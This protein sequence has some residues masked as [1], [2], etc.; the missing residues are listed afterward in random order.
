MPADL[1]KELLQKKMEEEKFIEQL[2]NAKNLEDYVMPVSVKAELRSYQRVGIKW[3][4]FL[5]RYQLHG[6][7]CD[8][9]GL[10]KTLQTICM[11][12][13][14]HH[15]KRKGGVEMS[16]LIVCPPTLCR[17]WQGEIVKFVGSSELRPLLYSGP[18]A[19]RAVIYK[20]FHRHNVIIS[21]YDVVRNDIEILLKTHWNYVVLD[22]GHIIK[23][24]KTKTTQA[25][26]QLRSD[27][28]LILS[29]TPIQNSV[30]E[31]WSLFDYLM[32]GFLG[33]EKQF[34]AKY[35]RP[36]V[37]SRDSKCSARDQEAGALAMEALHR[38]VLPFILRRMKEDVLKDLPPKITQD[39]Y[40][41]LS[42]IQVK[43]YEDFTRSK[44]HMFDESGASGEGAKAAAGSPQKAHVFQALQYLRKVC[45]HPK[46]VVDREHR[47]FASVQAMLRAS[48]SNMDDISHAAKLP[49]L[50]D[51]LL[52][53]GIG[54]PD[55]GNANIV[56]QHRALIFFQLKSMM[57]IVERDLLQKVMPSVSYL[58]LDGSVPVFDRQ[59]IVDRFNSD[60]SIDALLIS[61]A[62][63]ELVD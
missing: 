30:L 3:L 39:Y 36:I 38:Q 51:L 8:D 15:Y 60:V 37:S 63:G 9:M 42:P 18:A 43:I 56:V 34:T 32:P 35:S 54:A 61:S 22:E 45:N 23:N 5:N 4:A 40:C 2:M 58:R 59:G 19:V 1:P 13:S 49:A 50:R 53:C 25:I 17:H 41:D 27:H 46:L 20:E 6:I 29:G 26:K 21:S 48:N 14:D 10:G 44:S 12:A 47:E 62:V 55:S 57:D 28:R 24:G 52:Q 16:T 33:T 11:L 31:L 7:L